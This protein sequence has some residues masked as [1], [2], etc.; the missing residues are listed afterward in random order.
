[1]LISPQGRQ[2]HGDTTRREIRVEEKFEPLMTRQM[3]QV[4]PMK[5]IWSAEWPG[6]VKKLKK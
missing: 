4:T 1:M 5:K 6:F 2:A 3:D